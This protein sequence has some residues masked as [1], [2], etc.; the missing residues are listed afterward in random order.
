MKRI[1]NFILGF[2]VGGLIGASVALLLTPSSGDDLRAQ[3]QT[4]VR[5][6]QQET[7]SAA[8]ARRA[9]LE[10]QLAALRNPHKAD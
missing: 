4:R 9:E 6:I 3:L 8:A 7:Q 5:T 1:T 2:S 10:E